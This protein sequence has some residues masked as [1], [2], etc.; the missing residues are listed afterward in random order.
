MPPQTP[1]KN[2]VYSEQK[3]PPDTV[4]QPRNV[5]QGQLTRKSAHFIP[6]T[7]VVDL[8]RTAYVDIVAEIRKTFPEIEAGEDGCMTYD[9]P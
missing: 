5:F 7:D 2:S 3:D 8:P 6:P 9:P 4:T 1:Q